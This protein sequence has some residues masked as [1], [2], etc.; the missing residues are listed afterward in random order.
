MKNAPV[1]GMDFGGTWIRAAVVAA[2]GGCGPVVR[3]PTRRE[4]PAAEI[5]ADLVAI[6]AE[7][8][9]TAPAPP[10]GLAA[11]VATAV[12][13]DGRFLFPGNFPTL[14][15]FPLRE[16]LEAA[17]ALP[18]FCRNDADCFA[19]GE[20]WQGAGRGTRHFCGL[21]VGTGLGL[22]LILDGRL[23]RG[24]HGCAGEIWQTPLNGRCMEEE[25]CGPFVA[26]EYERRSGHSC[27]GPEIHRLAAQ[28]DPAAGAAYAALGRNLGV[29]A[30]FLVNTLD[31]ERIAI[32][33]A[34]A[35]AW[36]FFAPAMEETLR[37][38]TLAVAQ[39]RILPAV[40]GD[41]AALLGAARLCRE[42]LA[43]ASRQ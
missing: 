2:D 28:G 36:P 13:D 27:P 9:A 8:R 39:P 24:A 5:L 30:A 41:R 10:A 7:L 12:A 21:T 38:W 32:G 6:V 42:A 43:D 33:G 18:V 19:A 4:R 40:L 11:G 3:R 31:P 20:W 37:E 25:A 16:R 14:E 35:E 29:I 17:L 26:A 23:H 34:V 15:G 1:I 22:G